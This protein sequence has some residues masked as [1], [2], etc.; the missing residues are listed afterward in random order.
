MAAQRTQR[1]VENADI[2]TTQ[3][4]REKI[5]KIRWEI[6]PRTIQ[7]KKRNR[8][9]DTISS[10]GLDAW[11]LSLHGKTKRFCNDAIT[12]HWYISNRNACSDI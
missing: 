4:K 1:E 7:A 6:V 11:M 2:F 3:W 12:G 8:R 10:T 5:R 9:G